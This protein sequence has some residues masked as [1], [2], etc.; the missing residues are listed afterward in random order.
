MMKQQIWI[1]FFTISLIFLGNSA[2]SPET[3][4]LSN[5]EALTFNHVYE[6]AHSEFADDA[7]STWKPMF[8]GGNTLQVTSNTSYKTLI[9][10]LRSDIRTVKYQHFNPR[11]PPTTA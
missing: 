3:T 9:S 11:A 4:H 5:T 1:R 10:K 8:T 7:E 2:F 6:A